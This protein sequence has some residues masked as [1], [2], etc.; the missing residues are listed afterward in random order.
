MFTENNKQKDCITGRLLMTE[1]KIDHWSNCCGFDYLT[2]TILLASH[3]TDILSDEELLDYMVDTLIHEYIHKVLYDMFGITLT[4]L[5]DVVERYFR[6]TRLTEKTFGAK[7]HTGMEC[8]YKFI[9]RCGFQAFL[10]QYHIDNNNLNQAYI[11]TG[12]R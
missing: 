2:D 9:E 4:K 12:G 1:Y 10:E 11:I 8:W 6:S 7:E 5:F 3:N